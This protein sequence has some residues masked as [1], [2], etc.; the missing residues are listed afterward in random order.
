MEWWPGERNKKH[1]TCPRAEDN[2]SNYENFLKTYLHYILSFF[3]KKYC[4]IQVFNWTEHKDGYHGSLKVKNNLKPKRQSNLDYRF[5]KVNLSGH[6]PTI[7]YWD[8][9]ISRRQFYLFIHLFIVA[10]AL[11]C[12]MWAF[13]SCSKQGLLFL[14]VHGLLIAVASLCCGAR[15]LGAWASVVVAHGLSSCGSRALECRLSSCGARA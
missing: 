14:A 15:V 1:E 10:L 11:H 13:S 5:T 2:A 8:T 7:Y 6:L 9:V 12:C 3:M 4:F